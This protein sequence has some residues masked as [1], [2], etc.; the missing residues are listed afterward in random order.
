MCK[1]DIFLLV[2]TTIL[3]FDTLY[4][5]MKNYGDMTNGNRLKVTPHIAIAHY[6]ATFAARTAHF[7]AT[8]LDIQN[9]LTTFVAETVALESIDA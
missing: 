9:Y 5:C 4:L 7:I 2:T 8:F 6:M 1:V 3:T